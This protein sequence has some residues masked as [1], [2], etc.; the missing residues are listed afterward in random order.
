M[1]D[2]EVA[3]NLNAAGMPVVGSTGEQFAARI[4]EDIEGWTPIIKAGKIKVL[5][6]VN[7]K[8]VPALPDSPT[9]GE[10]VKGF[11]T[12]PWYGMFVPAGTPKS[13]IQ[14]LNAEIAKAL[15]SKDA[16]ERLA[17]VGCEPFKSSPEQFATLV[18]DDLPRW[19]KI[20][21]DAGATV[22]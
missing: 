8:R 6:V 1:R 22:D 4:R 17:G 10:T 2:P 14:Q 19:A 13:I 21:K 12:T 18:R 20:V 5:G 16:I 3:K 11:G 7:E 9:I 15:E